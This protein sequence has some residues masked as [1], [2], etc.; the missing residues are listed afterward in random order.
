MENEPEIFIVATPIGN[1]EDI[2]LRGIRIL[3]E[4][5]FIAAE[6]TRN[7][8]KL[9]SKLEIK[10]KMISMHEHNE[11]EK[12]DYIINLAL[13]GNKIAVVSDAG[14]PLISDPG[15]RLIEKG[16]EKGIKF[17]PVPGVSALTALVSVSGMPS[18]RFAFFGFLPAK[19]S[20]RDKILN[21]LVKADY[22]VLFYE[23]PKRIIK[24][25]NEI[26]EKTGNRHGVLGRELTKM[27]EEVIRGDLSEIVSVLEQKVNV[28]G[29]ISFMVQG[30]ELKEDNNL[31]IEEILSSYP[32]LYDEKPKKTAEKI[33]HEFNLRKNDV[34]EAILKFKG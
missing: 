6:D 13:E 1:L 22:P 10:N 30:G 27:H 14:T 7:T 16:L 2:T 29:E 20:S 31:S 17:V 33:A 18:D 25:L 5:D 19:K 23:S 11:K 32:G 8:G 24:T 15:F 3:K 26:I 9:L 12:A 34:Y 21:D 4:S 28:K